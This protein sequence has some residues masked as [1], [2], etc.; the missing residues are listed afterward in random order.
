VYF[1]YD[2]EEQIVLVMTNRKIKQNGLVNDGTQNFYRRFS[3]LSSV[4]IHGLQQSK[5]SS[6]TSFG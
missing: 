3:S 6:S 4:F 5:N 1:L 2:V